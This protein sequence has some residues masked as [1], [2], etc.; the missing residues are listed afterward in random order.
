[1]VG[2]CRG[3]GFYMGLVRA[4]THG[5]TRLPCAVDVCAKSL[6]V[7]WGRG[8]LFRPREVGGWAHPR[9]GGEAERWGRGMIGTPAEQGVGAGRQSM[10]AV[11]DH[12]RHGSPIHVG[13]K[14]T[15]GGG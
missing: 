5:R 4:M 10:A 13:L 8:W 14:P 11:S 9:P 2:R 6:P 12:P 7:E 3:Q 1:M 15:D